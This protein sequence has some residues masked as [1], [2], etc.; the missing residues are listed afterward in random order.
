MGVWHHQKHHVPRCTSSLGFGRTKSSDSRDK[1]KEAKD[2]D[3][4]AKEV[5]KSLA[6]VEQWRGVERPLSNSSKILKLWLAWGEERSQV[7]FVVKRISGVTSDRN[8]SQQV[9]TSSQQQQSQ[10]T[11]SHNFV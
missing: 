3:L 1:G 7:R 6:L 8:K 5:S 9:T 4:T 10:V 2:Q 11:T